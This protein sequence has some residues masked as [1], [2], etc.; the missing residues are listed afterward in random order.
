VASIVAA[1]LAV[2]ASANAESATRLIS[3]DVR[4]RANGAPLVGALVTLE[5][6]DGAQVAATRSGPQ[7]GFMIHAPAIGRY[8]L[9]AAARGYQA[10]SLSVGAAE[11]ASHIHFTLLTAGRS[12]KIGHI[13]SRPAH[14]DDAASGDR[15]AAD[16]IA[17]QGGMRVTDALGKLPGITISG[18]ALAPAGDAYVSLRGLRPAESQ[19][20]LDGHPIGPIGVQPNSPDTDGT[21]A[22]FNFQD[23]PYFAL[24]AVTITFGASG[25]DQLASD[26]LG[27]TIDLLTLAPTEHNAFV[28]QQGLGNAGRASTSLRVTGTTGAWG[29]ALV[30]GVA[31]TFG[32]FPPAAIAQTGLRG[33]NFTSET[34]SQL[35]YAVS[36]DAVLRDDLAKA[37]YSPSRSTSIALT[38][39]SATSWA[40]KTGEG[41]NDFIPA[42][43]VLANAPVG[44]S[45]RCPH[46]VFVSTDSGSSCLTP[47]AYAA[48]ASGPAGGGPGGWQALRNQGYDIRLTAGVARN[49][50]DADVFSDEYAFVYHRD[51]SAVSGPLDAFLNQ[52]S[53]RGVRLSDTLMTGAHTLGFGVSWLRQV[54]SGNGTVSDGSAF[55]PL[56]ATG[57]IDQSVFVRDVYAPDRQLSATLA[58]SLYTSSIDPAPHL[59]PRL[60][61][62]DRLGAHDTVRFAAGRLTA[63]PSL[64][65]D[66][67]NFVPVGALNP[68]CG[69]IAQATPSAPAAVNV[70][71]GPAGQLTAETGTDLELGY[72]RAFGRGATLGLTLY[73]MNV[74]DRIATGNFA[75]S[76][77]LPPSAIA[78]LSARINQFCGF[79]PVPG[80]VAFTF[81][82]PFNVATTRLRGIELGGRVRASTRL[83]FDYAFNVQSIV[84]NDLP[85][86]VLKTDPTLVNGL[87]AF[88]VPLQKATLGMELTTR[89]GLAFRLDGHA[90][91]P[92]NPQQLPG[93]AYADASLS[94]PLGKHVS[95]LFA[96][97]NVFNSHAQ[98]YGLVGS[99]LPYA[100]N[101]YNANLS[102]PY[103]QPFNERYGLAPAFLTLQ[104]TIAL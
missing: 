89:G 59:D 33:T 36:G 85:A 27:G 70:G 8:R 45:P 54:L 77:E 13:A 90:V 11:T 49:T 72:E 48:A 28:V 31:G 23:A 40:D 56:A 18:D 50:Y 64:E 73:D 19:T 26:S 83:A 30:H 46:G 65:T 93:Y 20:L 34:L 14:A 87:Q 80:A 17:S 41:D 104:G 71:S 44:A 4:D 66:R 47:A 101:S 84:L 88:E 79:P 3:G 2:I 68:D 5:A 32:S 94:G 98:T 95:L 38:A 52:W 102:T 57:R 24:R 74:R 29:Y 6:L 53:T 99:G 91:G 37:V 92:N 16:S 97:S 22:G 86:T 62:V 78:S 9:S 76:T 51:A 61:I 103:L 100:T 10:V 35:T 60:S 96:I 67:V 1:F 43:Y 12:N 42:G 69:A 58:A 21:L 39:Y 63:E 81:S 25:N 55:V 75:A 15:V 82:R 7:G